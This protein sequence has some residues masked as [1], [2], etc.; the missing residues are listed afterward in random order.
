[1][2]RR[3]EQR[4]SF[5]RRVT[6]DRRLGAWMAWLREWFNQR[7]SERR[8]GYGRRQRAAAADSCETPQGK[9]N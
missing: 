5:D 8:G 2:K 4:S 7:R 1:M 3:E 9:Q 6:V